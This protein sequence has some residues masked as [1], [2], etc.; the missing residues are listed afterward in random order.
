M[1]ASDGDDGPAGQVTY[2]MQEEGN[3]ENGN[4]VFSVGCKLLFYSRSVGQP[5]DQSVISWTTEHSTNVQSV[6][7]YISIHNVTSH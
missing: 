7:F 4:A 6:R 1:S 5:T 2:E 3:L